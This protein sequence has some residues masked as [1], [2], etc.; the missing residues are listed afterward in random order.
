MSQKAS[1][2]FLRV[3]KRSFFPILTNTSGPRLG[4]NSPQ[5]VGS[6]KLRGGF[7]Q[8]SEAWALSQATA[9]R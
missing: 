3:S 9:P 6:Q 8:Q 4:A 2:F 5:A 1:K 7:T